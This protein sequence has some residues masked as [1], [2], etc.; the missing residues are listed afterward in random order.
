MPFNI[1]VTR[2]IICRVSLKL[3]LPQQGNSK[4]ENKPISAGGGGQFIQL[5]NGFH[6]VYIKLDIVGPANENVTLL[7]SKYEQTISNFGL[8]DYCDR[9]IERRHRPRL[10]MAEVKASHLQ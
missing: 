6:V 1:F 3:D 4:H 7:A 8:F 9:T 2:R 10:A 5:V